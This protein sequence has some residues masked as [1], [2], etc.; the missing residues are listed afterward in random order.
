MPA[1]PLVGAVTM[2]PPA[3]FSSLT[4][5]ANRF[6]HSMARSGSVTPVSAVRVWNNDGARRLTFRPPGRIP[7]AAQPL[8]THSRMTAHSASSFSRSSASLRQVSSLASITSEMDMPSRLADLQEFVGGGE[9][10][11]QDGGVGHHP[12]AGVGVAVHHEAAADGVEAPFA[13]DGAG[14]VQGAE[15]HA[16]GVGREGLAPVQHHVLVPVE[17]HPVVPAHPQFGVEGR[18]G[19]L[20]IR[21]GGVHGFRVQPLEAQD[22]GLV[23]AVAPAGGAERAEQFGLHAP[24]GA[25]VSVALEPVGEQLRCPHRADRV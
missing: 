10:V 23:G 12:V 15:G 13:E 1:A 6:T 18:R 21:R 4:A 5:S 19:H 8:S 14:V 9:R 7:S 25:Q 17:V 11:G 3:A 16:V 2:R 20:V 24:G 22:H